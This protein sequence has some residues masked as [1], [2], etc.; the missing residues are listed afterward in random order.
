MKWALCEGITFRISFWSHRTACFCP[1]TG[2]ISFFLVAVD[3]F[4][5]AH[6][7]KAL[8]RLG[9]KEAIDTTRDDPKHTKKKTTTKGF[10]PTSSPTN[11]HLHQP[12]NHPTNVIQSLYHQP[13][14]PPYASLQVFF[15]TVRLRCPR[16]FAELESGHCE[17]WRPIKRCPRWWLQTFFYVPPYL[18]EMIQFD[19]YF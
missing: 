9:W 2:F 5:L 13:P 3:L 17:T 14:W 15:G 18:R 6:G 1:G 7:P 10:Q 4:E 16:N 19:E 8:V 11:P 12:T